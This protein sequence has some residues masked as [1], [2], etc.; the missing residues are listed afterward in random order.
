M[1]GGKGEALPLPSF[2]Y[3]SF[4][5]VS[6]SVSIAIT[7][8][9]VVGEMHDQ[10]R[11]V[12][13]AIFPVEFGKRL[14]DRDFGNAHMFRNFTVGQSLPEQSDD[15]PLPGIRLAGTAE[16]PAVF[17][18]GLQGEQLFFCQFRPGD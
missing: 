2:L 6:V 1:T 18:G 17:P 5:S 11:A 3:V 10:S 16:E 13:H 14:F 4:V 12:G 9:I 8:A 15:E 7:V